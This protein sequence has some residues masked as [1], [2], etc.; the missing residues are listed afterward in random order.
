MKGLSKWIETRRLGVATG[1]GEVIF[2]GESRDGISGRGHP[3]KADG[4]QKEQK[5][6][7][8]KDRSSVS[9]ISFFYMDHLLC[10]RIRKPT[11]T[12]GG[13]PPNGSCSFASARRWIRPFVDDIYVFCVDNLTTPSCPDRSTGGLAGFRPSAERVVGN[14]S[15]E[16][17]LVG[18]FPFELKLP[19]H[20]IMNHML[21]VRLSH[22]MGINLDV[23]LIR[24]GL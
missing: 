2:A 20:D 8:N 17:S 9:D 12:A 5:R 13:V 23:I 22:M 24:I 16:L 21:S 7:P 19:F 3:E 15:Y 4:L 11:A 6:H 10:N 18:T 1:A 14:R